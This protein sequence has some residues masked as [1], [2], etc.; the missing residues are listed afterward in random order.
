MLGIS[1]KMAIDKDPI[2]SQGQTEIFREINWQKY[3]FG[4]NPRSS[5]P[6][7]CFLA[8]ILWWREREIIHWTGRREAK[9]GQTEDAE[10][11]R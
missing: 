7:A 8:G 1:H 2:L 5:A 3:D 6:A 4:E 11:S 9:D 10:R